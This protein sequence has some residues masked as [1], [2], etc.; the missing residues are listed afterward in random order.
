VARAT[1]VN[2]GL[3]SRVRTPKRMSERR[4][5]MG[6]VWSRRRMRAAYQ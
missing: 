1:R 2:P 5:C 3:L 4:W 6:A